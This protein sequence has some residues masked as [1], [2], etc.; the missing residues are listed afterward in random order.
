MRWNQVIDRHAHAPVEQYLASRFTNVRF[1]AII[2][3]HG[4]PSLYSH[5]PAYLSPGGT[6][7][8]V[9]V[10]FQEYTFLSVL[11][12]TYLMLKQAWWSQTLGG[13]SREYI[14]VTGIAN[15][16]VMEQ[17]RELVEKRRLRVV[18]DSCWR[19]EDALMV[20]MDPAPSI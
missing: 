16:E 14:G 13:V 3:A 19:I 20:R 9:G 10:A 15:L 8:S 11:R 2:D 18:I 4:V 6:Y 1:S 7:V 17:L 12:A 5:C